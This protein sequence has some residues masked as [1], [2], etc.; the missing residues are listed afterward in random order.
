MSDY[1]YDTGAS[2]LVLSEGL[3]LA[4]AH[5]VMVSAEHLEGGT[6]TV[7][8]RDEDAPAIALAILE[9]AGYGNASSRHMAAAWRNLNRHITERKAEA[10]R[11]AEEQKA[12]DFYRVQGIIIREV[13]DLHVFRY[14]AARKFFEES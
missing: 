14:N 7:P 9:A 8:V 11:E 13:D 6:I 2:R 3:D 4:D 1:E 5:L 10:E 12:R